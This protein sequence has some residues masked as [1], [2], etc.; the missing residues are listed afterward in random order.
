MRSRSRGRQCVFGE[1]KQC[2]TLI[3]GIKACLCGEVSKEIPQ[4]LCELMLNG[5]YLVSNS[6]LFNVGNIGITCWNCI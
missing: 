5:F 2:S 3:W 4:R 1:T 6:K